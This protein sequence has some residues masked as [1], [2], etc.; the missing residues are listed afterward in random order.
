MPSNRDLTVDII[1]A[2]KQRRKATEGK[3]RHGLGAADGFKWRAPVVLAVKKSTKL[4]VESNK[5]LNEHVEAGAPENIAP[6]GTHIKLTECHRKPRHD[7]EHRIEI[8][9]KPHFYT[10]LGC[11][12][13]FL[14]AEGGRQRMGK[15]RDIARGISAML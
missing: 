1:A 13:K 2:Q 4:D 8:G 15:A 12:E 11:S 3:S 5:M 7:A 14:I 10:I 9:V 6:Y